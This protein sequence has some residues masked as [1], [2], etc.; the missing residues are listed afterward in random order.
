MGTMRHRV[1]A[2]IRDQ[3]P[4]A[5]EREQCAR[6][7]MSDPVPFVSTVAEESVTQINAENSSSGHDEVHLAA[8]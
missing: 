6:D 8:P 3:N 4:Q 2:Q 5:Q 1:A 7:Q